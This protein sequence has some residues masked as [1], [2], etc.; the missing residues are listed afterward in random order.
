MRKRPNRSPEA[1]FVLG[2][3]MLA[4][5]VGLYSYALGLI[6]GGLLLMLTGWLM[7]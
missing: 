7:G 2:E 6:A 5:G 3:I 1:I 4:V